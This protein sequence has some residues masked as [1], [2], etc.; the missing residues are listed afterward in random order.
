MDGWNTSFLLGWPIFRCYVSFR[1]CMSLLWQSYA[2]LR[3][4]VHFQVLVWLFYS[5]C[6][7]QMTHQ[8][9]K[10][11]KKCPIWWSPRWDGAVWRPVINSRINYQLQLVQDFR[12]QKLWVLKSI[13]KHLFNLHSTS[14]LPS[15]GGFGFQVDNQFLQ[16]LGLGPTCLADPNTKS[17]IPTSMVSCSNAKARSR[18]GS[19]N[20]AFLCLGLWR[21]FLQ[22]GPP[23]DWCG[24]IKLLTKQDICQA[25]NSGDY[26]Q[27]QWLTKTEESWISDDFGYDHVLMA[28]ISWINHDYHNHQPLNSWVLDAVSTRASAMTSW[29]CLWFVVKVGFA[30]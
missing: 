10:F 16:G 30:V 29:H 2:K 12:H 7:N 1:G 19:Q 20:C 26:P 17:A 4:S 5:F 24:R 14:G 13:K 3:S 22:N 21:F 6:G 9:K 18:E 23:K 8:L 27:K 25:M 28:W 15:N 11:H